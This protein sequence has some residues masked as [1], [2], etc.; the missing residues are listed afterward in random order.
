VRNAS[1]AVG[2]GR[3]ALL[4]DAADGRL[5]VHLEAVRGLRHHL[6]GVLQD[7]QGERPRRLRRQPQP[8]VGGAA[9]PQI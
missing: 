1:A 7:P 4:G 3:E 8:E 5:E 2:P 9:L 6:Q